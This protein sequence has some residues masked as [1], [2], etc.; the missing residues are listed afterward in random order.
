MV[1]HCTGP[2]LHAAQ[3]RRS[4][5]QPSSPQHADTFANDYVALSQVPDTQP[6]CHLRTQ[7]AAR[8]P[9][10]WKLQQGLEMPS[11]IQALARI[12]LQRPS[13]RWS[14]KWAALHS[15][16]CYAAVYAYTAANWKKLQQGLEMPS[17]IQALAR[18]SLQRPSTRWSMKWAALHS[19]SCYA[20]V[21]AYTA[22]NWKKLQQGL[23][24]PSHMQALAR[25]SL[26]RPSTR[27]AMKWA[28]LHSSPCR[29]AVYL[30]LF[31]TQLTRT[32]SILREREVKVVDRSLHNEQKHS[33]AID[34]ANIAWARYSLPWAW[35]LGRPAV[36]IAIG[37]Y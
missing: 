14:M 29:A 17:H 27:W 18:L 5:A 26:Q 19:N 28:A 21:Y 3:F 7:G 8:L 25:L 1:Y 31:G 6:A 20:A 22:A 13:T 32:Y 12:S 37:N 36:F 30:Y 34:C 4:R 23:E 15:N 24:M 11:H 9:S 10:D 16:S 35:R 2:V 33:R